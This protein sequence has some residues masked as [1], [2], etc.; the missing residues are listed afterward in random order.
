MTMNTHSTWIVWKWRA[1]T[2]YYTSDVHTN[3]ITPAKKINREKSFALLHFWCHRRSH[4]NTI[5]RFPIARLV[6][7]SLEPSVFSLLSLTIISEAIVYACL[8]FSPLLFYFY[9]FI[10]T[11]L[12]CFFSC[13]C[14]HLSCLVC[15]Y[16]IFRQLYNNWSRTFKCRLKLESFSRK[17]VLWRRKITAFGWI[18]ALKWKKGI[19]FSCENLTKDKWLPKCGWSNFNNAVTNRKYIYLMNAITHHNEYKFNIR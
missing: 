4:R 17:E 5:R 7:A 15:F 11:I 19:I 3:T 12:L 2:Y 14:I 13:V 10:L 1:T 18:M 9:L 6:P 16:W 8:C